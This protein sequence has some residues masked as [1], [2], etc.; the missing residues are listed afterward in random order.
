[1]AIELVDFIF[2][3]SVLFLFGLITALIADRRGANVEL[4][5]ILGCCLGPIAALIAYGVVGRICLHCKRRIHS[6]ATVCPHCHRESDAVSAESKS[7]VVPKDPLGQGIERIVDRIERIVDRIF[8][9]RRFRQ[10]MWFTIALIVLIYS[11]SFVIFN[12]VY[13]D[14]SKL[15]RQNTVLDSLTR[16]DSLTYTLNDTRLI[17]KGMREQI[18]KNENKSVGDSL[19]D[20]RFIKSLEKQI[21]TNRD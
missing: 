12:R 18:K 21:E 10:L 13:E 5:F 11:I 20:L 17:L 4:W 16:L 9:S 6:T 15:D 14:S 8:S 7:I 3:C 2:I 19:V 1:M